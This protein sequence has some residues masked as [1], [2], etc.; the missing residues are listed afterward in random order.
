[1]RVFTFLIAL[2][3]L[4]FGTTGVKHEFFSTPSTCKSCPRMCHI[5]FLLPKL[6]MHTFH[7]QKVITGIEPSPI[8]AASPTYFITDI[9]H[10][11]HIS[12]PTY[13]ITDICPI[14]R[15]ISW[16]WY[17]SLVDIMP[18]LTDIVLTTEHMRSPRYTIAD[19]YHSRHMSSPTYTIAD[20]CRHRQRTIVAS[21]D[22][23]GFIR[24]RNRIAPST[25]VYCFILTFYYCQ[26]W[27]CPGGDWQLYIELSDGVVV[28][29]RQCLL[30]LQ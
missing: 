12:S 17:M 11:R 22:G 23:D 30:I 3:I 28:N 9:C 20:M 4:L 10:R 7:R 1:M 29:M 26:G 6:C 15:N 21:S 18:Y 8:Y 25:P 16:H 24:T 2:F 27:N 14:S 5:L 13:T 19:M